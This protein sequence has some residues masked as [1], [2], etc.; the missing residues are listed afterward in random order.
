MVQRAHKIRLDPNNVQATA[1]SRAAGVA[2]FAY[3][4]A[5]AQWQEQ[6]QAHKDD[7]SKPR[8]SQYALRK[9]LNSIK[10]SEFPWMLESTKCAPQEAIIA[11]GGAF[12]NF[13]AGRARHPTFKKRGRHDSFKLSSGNFRID[14]ARIHIPKVGWVRMREPLRYVDAKQVSVT[15]SRQADRWFASVQCGSS[16]S[17][18]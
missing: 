17:T 7:P 16:Q 8:P 6:Y 18:V 12:D 5:L 1:L 2:R 10:R 14:G 4:W 3:N 13:F 9:Q 11:L 15:V